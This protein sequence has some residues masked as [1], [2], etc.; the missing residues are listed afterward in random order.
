[1]FDQRVRSEI[2]R[3]TLLAGVEVCVTYEGDDGFHGILGVELAGFFSSWWFVPLLRVGY[4][5][6]E[7]VTAIFFLPQ[8]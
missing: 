6:R 5:V 8:A 2:G 3:S 1:M 7:G 4:L